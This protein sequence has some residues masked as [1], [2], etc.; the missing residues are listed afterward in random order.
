MKMV[1]LMTMV[2]ITMRKWSSWYGNDGAGARSWRWWC[3]QRWQQKLKFLNQI[4][5]TNLISSLWKRYDTH[6]L[7][8]Q[9]NSKY[10]KSAWV[11][12]FLPGHMSASTRVAVHYQIRKNPENTILGWT[13]Y[14]KS[15]LYFCRQDTC[16]VYAA[17]HCATCRVHIVHDKYTLLHVMRH[18]AIQHYSMVCHTTR[19]YH[20]HTR[21]L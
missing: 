9:L 17:L 12:F 15:T 2:V 13:R 3:Q 20:G 16:N 10:I 14:S 7:R 19:L 5:S 6:I 21:P 11:I 18:S 4:K 1:M 8:C